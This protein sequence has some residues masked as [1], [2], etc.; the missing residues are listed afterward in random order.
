VYAGTMNQNGVLTIEV[1]KKE[2]DTIL[3]HIIKIVEEAQISKAPI[4]HIADKITTFF[5]PV[6]LLLASATFIT[7]YFF[8]ESAYFGGA[9]VKMIAVLI[10]ACPCALGLATPLSIMVAS[11]RGAQ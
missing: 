7:W 9:I 10:V 4:Q 8:L 1:K 6:V 3:S 2:A 5:I 11:G